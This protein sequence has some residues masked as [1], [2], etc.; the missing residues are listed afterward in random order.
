MTIAETEVRVLLFADTY[1]NQIGR[2]VRIV[3]GK[4]ARYVQRPPSV[5]ATKVFAST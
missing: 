4:S 1:H 2:I 3:C 5:S